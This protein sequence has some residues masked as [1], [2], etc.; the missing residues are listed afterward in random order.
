MPSSK[1]IHGHGGTKYKKFEP[2]AI[3]TVTINGLVIHSLRP[4]DTAKVQPKAGER[5]LYLIDAENLVLSQAQFDALEKA[6]GPTDDDIKRL[7][8]K[9]DQ[10]G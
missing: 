7:N 8:D 5:V 6:P 1:H 9:L 4:S 10:K 2:H 3:R